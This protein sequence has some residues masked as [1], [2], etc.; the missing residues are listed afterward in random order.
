MD[1]FIQVAN[2]LLPLFYALVTMGYGFLFFGNDPHAR[3]MTPP[4]FFATLALH[5]A[6]LVAL[7]VRFSQF[8]VA[9]VSQQLSAVAFAVALVYAFVEW[10]GR[11]PSTGFLMTSFATLLEV[12][13]AF[14]RNPQPPD[15][16]IF[17]DPL[18]A[19]HAGFGIVGYTGFAVGAV[20]GFLFLRLYSEI[21]RRR[22]SLFFDRLPPLEVLERLM[23]WALAAGFIAFTGTVVSGAVMANLHREL[24]GD[25]WALD[26]KML[27][28]FTIWGFYG[29][30]LLLR[31][32]RRLQGRQMA[33][34]SL[35]GIAAIMFS[36]LALNLFFTEVHGFL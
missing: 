26:P 29:L 33:K 30:A 22:F 23:T 2:V 7:G 11:E 16:A 5:L 27:G 8:P 31:R 15:I 14:L 19:T 17:H 13:S 32:L 10:R 28:T 36:L 1:L 24:F 25:N 6:Y 34:A 35:A 18:F 20:Y 9:S 12:L 3:K 21:K 4:L